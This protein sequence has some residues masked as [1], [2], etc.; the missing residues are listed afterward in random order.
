[1]EVPGSWRG[2]RNRLVEAPEEVQFY[3]EPVA[4]LIER[5]PWEVSLSY[6]FARVEKAHIMSLYCGVVKLHK[7]DA[8]L[9]ATAVDQFENTRHQFQIM[10]ENIFGKP[11]PK[12]TRKM[13]ETAQGVRD[14]ALHGKNVIDK[15]YRA[16]VV[17]IIEY[18]SEF[19]QH[20]SQLAGFRP[21]G[22]LRG[23]KGASASL[24]RSTSRWVLKGIGL[25]LD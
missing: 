9:A 18:A 25:P 16:A 22:D 23:Y 2:V 5:Y 4:E 24:D 10:F 14:R 21:F 13:L 15:D 8:G 17:S 7:T 11:I 1:M 20:C 3:L 6:L 12:R 19:N